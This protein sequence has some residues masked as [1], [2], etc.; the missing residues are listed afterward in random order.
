[1]RSFLYF[2]AATLAACVLLICFLDQPL[3]LFIHQHTGW[4]VPFFTAYTEGA[5]WLWDW[6]LSL[7]L[8]PLP[9]PYVLLVAA[10]LVGRWGLRRPGASLLL[11]VLLTHIASQ[12]SSNVLKGVV[13]RLRP[14]VLFGAGYEG[15]GLW[16]NGPHNDSFPSSHTA[17]YL[18]LFWP[19]AVAWPRYRVPLLV[20]PGLIML[21][22]LV[23]GAHY[24]S[25]VW[26]AAWLV[27]AWTA[28]FGGVLGWT[29]RRAANKKPLAIQ[30]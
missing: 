14:E 23:L 5:D 15:L 18:S 25:D 30:R 2:T 9:G 19:L 17:G 27:V 16:A 7:R 12:V 1:L 4:A 3:A 28:G 29:D 21:G 22:R 10:Y 26:F 11:L 13:H 8:G 6:L 24:L 20:L